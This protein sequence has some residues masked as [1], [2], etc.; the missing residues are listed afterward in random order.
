MVSILR[1]VTR[2]II[3][4]RLS[5]NVVEDYLGVRVPKLNICLSSFLLCIAVTIYV[6]VFSYFTVLRHYCFQSSAWDLGIFTQSLYTT[7]FQGKLLGY[8]L[9]QPTVNPSGSFLGIHF[10]PILFL[11]VP[12]YRLAPF[13]ETLLILQSI[14]LAAGA[15]ALYAISHHLLENR[16]ASLSLAISYLLY[17]PLHAVNWFD[18]HVQAFIPL[19]FFLMYYFYVKKKYKT[20]FLFLILLLSTIEMMPVLVLPFGLYCLLSNRTNKRKV[21]YSL[22]IMCTSIVFFLLASSVK[23]YLNPI[24]SATYGAWQ[25]WGSDYLQMLGNVVA[26]PVEMLTYFFTAFPMEKMLYFLWLTVPLLFLPLHSTKE[27]IL[28][29]MPWI[30]LVFLSTYTGY[31]AYHYAAFVI[32]QIFVSSVYGLK[33]I[34]KLSNKSVMKEALIFRYSE[35]TLIGIIIAFILISPFGI[36]PQAKQIYIHGLPENTSHKEVLR[37]MLQLIPNN[38]SVY[39]SFHIAP[40]LAN[41][42]ELYAHSVPDKPPD[43][44]VADLK[45]PDSSISLGVFGGTPIA[46]MKELLGKY[47]YSLMAS[48]DG[49]LIYSLTE[50]NTTIFEPLTMAFDSKDLIL[51][52]GKVVKDDNS[53]SG[54]VLTHDPDDLPYGFWH[55]SYVVLPQGKYEV[56]YRVKC[57]EVSEGHLLTFDITSDSGATLLARK[58]VYDHDIASNVWNHVILE[59]SIDEPKTSI[60][61]RGSYVSSETTHYLDFVML[62]QLSLGADITFGSISFNYMDLAVV[63]GKTLQNGVIIHETGDPNTLLFGLY[64]RLPPGEYQTKYWLRLDMPYQGQISSLEIE[65][66]NGTKLAEKRVFAE[67]FDQ[68]K[69][70]Q[71]FSLKFTLHSSTRVVEI[72]GTCTEGVSTQFSYLEVLRVDG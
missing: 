63:Q 50:L 71:C 60:E 9:E 13:A 49:I 51:D 45:S 17:T 69:L 10:S 57:E 37:Q 42:L 68:P 52:S 70:W 53:M 46:G 38:A 27:F 67:D 34:S 39:T 20:S 61:F 1:R 21:I 32:P 14:I 16:F 8:T 48:I 66:F 4:R 5:F 41:R 28:L 56:A 54:M 26:N 55:S 43:Y 15:V 3:S 36:V 12:L 29:V 58:H 33:R 24:S 47:N 44:I 30:A 31:Y 18:F 35:W 7:S 2:W 64:A 11:L 23:A 22:A 59:F 19:F 6:L 62:T 65:D 25:I 72:R 40:H